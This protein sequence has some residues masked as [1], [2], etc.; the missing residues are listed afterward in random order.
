MLVNR[1]FPIEFLREAFFLPSRKG[2]IVRAG[3][4]P[5]MREEAEK[6]QGQEAIHVEASYH[7][8]PE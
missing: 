1:G 7:D 4:W 6:T 8:Y 2:E 5:L 3:T